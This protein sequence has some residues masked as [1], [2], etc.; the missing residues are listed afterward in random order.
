M[1]LKS[2]RVLKIGAIS[3]L[4]IILAYALII[5]WIKPPKSA[6]EF[7]DMFGGLNVILTALVFLLTAFSLYRN[8]DLILENRNTTKNQATIQEI[9][10]LL[11]RIKQ[12]H[13]DDEMNNDINRMKSRISD[14]FE[15]MFVKANNDLPLDM[16]LQES[17]QRIIR[18]K[19]E[20]ANKDVIGIFN[21]FP[22]YLEYVHLVRYTVEKL[23]QLEDHSANAAYS[24]ILLT[25]FKQV[26][27][28]M[29]LIYALFYEFAPGSN[30][31][32]TCVFIDELYKR[33]FISE[34]YVRSIYPQGFFASDKHLEYAIRSKFEMIE[35]DL[36]ARQ[37]VR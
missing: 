2:S 17:F 18:D 9:A 35:S 37:T 13:A 10:M 1:K 8:E 7:G 29:L 31:G 33:N 16:T 34:S 19:E 30:L 14:C 36:I 12:L 24:L 15:T 20:K 23:N 4:G 21:R 26:H 28:N 3:F 32:D 11:D 27:R 25:E 6:G 22:I 5:W